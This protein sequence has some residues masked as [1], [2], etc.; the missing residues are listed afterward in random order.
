[1]NPIIYFSFIPICIFLLFVL[2][3]M[4]LE[5]KWRY[6]V[7]H[8]NLILIILGIISGIS[9]IILSILSFVI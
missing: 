7:P 5:N 8:K 2:I 9:G 3:T 4:I 1:M 6:T